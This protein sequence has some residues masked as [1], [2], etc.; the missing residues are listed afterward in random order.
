M[1]RLLKLNKFLIKKNRVLHYTIAIFALIIP[2]LCVLIGYISNEEM[3]VEQYILVIF[4][5]VDFIICIVRFKYSKNG[6]NK[7]LIM[8]GY[9]L[10]DNEKIRLLLQL[11]ICMGT[12]LVNLIIMGILIPGLYDVRVC[13]IFLFS[14]MKY[15]LL[16]SSIY[17]IFDNDIAAALISYMFFAIETVLILLFEDFL[18]KQ[19]SAFAA[20]FICRVMNGFYAKDDIIWG[21]VS[22]LLEISILGVIASRTLAQRIRDEKVI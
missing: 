5:L 12:G 21:I 7:K 6:L 18:P 17:V 10:Y 4:W 1:N 15:V 22:S 2:L 13:V 20:G 19:A 16:L 8:Y 11:V 9:S 14:I 3:P